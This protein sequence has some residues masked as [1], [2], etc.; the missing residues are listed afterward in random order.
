[1]KD[2]QMGELLLQAVNKD[3]VYFFHALQTRVVP[4]LVW[5]KRL[6]HCGDRI[7]TRLRQHKLISNC[8]SFNNDCVSCKLGKS[9][10]LPFSDVTHDTTAPLQLIY[11]D[12]WQS[13]VLSNLGFK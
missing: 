4:G 2:K 13:P 8:S 7:L 1:M 12:V 5:H 11:Y 10:R 6:G 9:H 3:H